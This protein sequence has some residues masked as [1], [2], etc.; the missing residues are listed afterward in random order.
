MELFVLDLG[1]RQTKLITNQA[2]EVLP[3][4]FIDADNFGDRSLMSFAK[5]QVDTS[6]YVSSLE[7]STTYV[8]GTQMDLEYTGVVTD[9]LA[10][11]LKRY[12]SLDFKLLVDF[13]LARLAR[14]YDNA[15]RGTLDVNVVTGVPTKDHTNEA[16]LDAVTAAIKGEHTITVDGE[17]LNIRVHD[18]YILPQSLGT[19]I[20]EVTSDEG[21][22]VD[23]A[24]LNTSVV[25]VDNGGGTLLIDILNKM[26]VDTKKRKQSNHGA[27]VLYEDIVNRIFSKH[28]HNI[29]EYEA[30][31]I[32]RTG[33]K[34]KYSITL[35]GIEDVDVTTEVM[36]A[37]ESYTKKVIAE[38]KAALKTTERISQILVTGGTANLLIK[39]EFIKAFPNTKFVE[40]S[41]LANAKGF[42]KFA[43]TEG[44]I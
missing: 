40:N 37:R 33:V 7:P 36:K 38:V 15:K 19:V 31:R 28:G 42:Y 21:E 10:F 17:K 9:T 23:S 43:I 32:T 20:N 3:S 39:A 8:W 35:D 1:N 26:N 27:Y 24:I 34:D 41:E 30:E 13:A 6:D 2:Q 12:E 18:V 16:I 4:Y 5:A 14:N 44:M 25:V 29:T 22:I 11:G